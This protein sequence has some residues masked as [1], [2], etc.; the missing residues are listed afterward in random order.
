MTLMEQWQEN[1]VSR[2]K[3]RAMDDAFATVRNCPK[4]LANL[5]SVE[6]FEVQVSEEDW[7]LACNR[8]RQGK[9]FLLT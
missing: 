4:G 7:L 6:W 8:F 9:D 2:T 5:K 3:A 1:F